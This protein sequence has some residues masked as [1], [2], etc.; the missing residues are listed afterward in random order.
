MFQFL[1]ICVDILHTLAMLAWG[2]GL[3]LLLW[4]RWPRASRAYVWY[5][6][7]FVLFSV[8]THQIYGE[9]FLTKLARDLRAIGD[10]NVLSDYASFSVRLVN[11]V[12]GI[13]PSEDS[14]V[15]AWEIGLTVSALFMLRYMYKTKRSEQKLRLIETV[16]PAVVTSDARRPA[17][18]PDGAPAP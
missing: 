15:L 18:P 4:H 5:A 10:P 3:P 9:C 14:A 7:T 11:F 1:A 13:R 12:A 2:L 6:L 16:N 8:G 17:C